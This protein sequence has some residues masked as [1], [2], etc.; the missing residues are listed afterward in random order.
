MILVDSDA[1][2]RSGNSAIT[3]AGINAGC[4]KQWMDLDASKHKRL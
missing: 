1:S 2:D 4:W 3:T